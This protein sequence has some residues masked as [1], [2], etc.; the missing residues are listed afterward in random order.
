MVGVVG[1]RG[2]QGQEFPVTHIHDQGHASLRFPATHLAHKG[3]LGHLLQ[4]GIQGELQP[5]VITEQG[6]GQL[7]IR[8]GRAIGAA[9]EGTHRFQAPEVPFPALLKTGLRNALHVQEAHDVGEQGSLGIDAL[10]MG[11][12]IQTTDAQTPDPG[13]GLRIQIL[14]EFHPTPAV[15]HGAHQILGGQR[16]HLRQ[17]VRD[18]LRRT[19]QPGGI[20]REIE[21][22]R[23]GPEGETLL[24]EGHDPAIPI[25]DGAALP[26]WVD[27]LGLDG[28]RPG[29]KTGTL[30]HLQPGETTQQTDQGET[31]KG[32]DRDQAPARHRLQLDHLTRALPP[33][34]SRAG[35][36]Q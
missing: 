8:K 30:D 2:R 20:P 23:M 34:G 9:Q 11:L 28:A 14:T 21:I 32:E 3:L 25:D 15:P 18:G 27:R 5:Q 35:A 24:I 1:G 29:M 6:A 19:H 10:G 16:Q 22:L 4:G 33:S 12:Q 26:G 17:L 7:T 31:Q 13:G 36:H